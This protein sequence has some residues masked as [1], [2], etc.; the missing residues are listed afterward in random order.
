MEQDMAK[1]RKWLTWLIVAGLIFAGYWWLS[2]EQPL[3]V[4]IIHAEI[5]LVEQTI[6]NTRAGT[7]TPCQRARMSLPIGGQIESIAVKEGQLVEKGQLL[8]SLWNLDRQAALAEAKAMLASSKKSQQSACVI[9]SNARKDAN[10]QRSLLKKKLTSADKVD[11]AIANAEATLASCQA[12]T[13]QIEASNATVDKVAAMLEQT[14]LTAPFA[15]IVAEITGE[16]GE[17]TT[18]SPPG[19]P[20]PPAVDLLTHDCHY[21]SAPIDEVDAA[22]LALGKPVRITLDAFRNDTMSGTLRR[23]SPYVQDYEKQARTVT[24][25]VDFLEHKNP[26]LLAGYSSDVE[27]I[28]DSKDAVLRLPSDL[29]INNE[30]VWLL[31]QNNIIEQRKVDVGLSNW[32][33]SEI[34][35]GLSTTDRVIGSIGQSGVQAGVAAMA[36]EDQ[37][38]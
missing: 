11:A 29:I 18:P 1:W 20:T 23:I 30:F 16:I 15:G 19:V 8:I 3:S 36:V 7:V 27:V 32:Q 2:R 31:N 35:A 38:P 10:R 9:S 22:A 26:H 6:A 13:A 28:L 17:Y 4:N 33:F 14:Y 12:M 37:Q 21:V 5:G 34:V 25:E 24:I